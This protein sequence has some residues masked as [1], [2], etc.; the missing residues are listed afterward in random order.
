VRSSPYLPKDTEV[1][2]FIYDVQT[3][4]LRQVV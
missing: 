1:A 3:G 2:G 4:R